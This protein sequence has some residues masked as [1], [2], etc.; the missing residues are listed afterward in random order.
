MNKAAKE[1]GSAIMQMDFR[2][3]VVGGKA[4][5]VMPPTIEK[6]ASVGYYFSEAKDGGSIKEV[7]ASL[8][9]A[10]LWAH[11]LSW[12]IE[13]NDSLYDTF[14]KADANELVDA[15]V[16]SLSLISAENFLKL[17]A[18]TKNVARLTAKPK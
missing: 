15:L 6:I 10:R 5:T 2:T 8:A 13:G 3:V 16:E 1:V 14:C 11:A 12:L 17:L 4:Y 7:I 9:D 18:L